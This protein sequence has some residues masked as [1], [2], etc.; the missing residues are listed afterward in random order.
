MNN[1]FRFRVNIDEVS[2]QLGTT[3]DIIEKNVKQAVRLISIQAHDYIIQKAS[4]E[5]DGTKRE[6]YLGL[7]K[8]GTKASGKS[9][10]EP[11]VNTEAKN[12]RWNKL[13]D[14]VWV[15]TLD[16]SA[17]WLEEG[18]PVTDM[19]TPEWLLKPGKVKVAKD[20]STYRAIPMTKMKGNKPTFS[21]GLLGEGP[22][23]DVLSAVKSAAR[24]QNVS[25][26][27]IEMADGQ[28]KL[29]VLHKLNVKE[30]FTRLDHPSWFSKPR[31]SEEAAATGLKTHQGI[32]HLQGAV[33]MQRK[34]AKGQVKKETVVF[35]TVSSKHKGYR[36]QAP[37][38][39]PLG[40]FKA[41][42]EFANKQ[43]E[44]AIRKIDEQLRN[45]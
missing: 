10:S 43:W 28:P 14:G 42:Y 20:G 24:K 35:R 8:F 32:F 41:A 7:G 34:N 4:T 45:V 31:N 18:R 9:D 40:F 37:A 25:L 30:P 3:A 36:W 33:V 12:V 13:S 5:L 1:L 17:S 38:Q 29:G 44:E 23:G 11:G 39:A 26:S 21:T 6:M 16:E 15:V 2:R 27:K 22:G 19:A